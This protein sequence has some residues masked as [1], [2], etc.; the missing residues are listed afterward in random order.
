MTS[1]EIKK[2]EDRKDQFKKMDDINA[3]LNMSQTEL[4]KHEY[5][6]YRIKRLE[7]V[8]PWLSEQSRRMQQNSQS[9]NQG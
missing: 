3:I 6:K 5:L 4:L 8:F 7:E 2:A 1:E 9:I